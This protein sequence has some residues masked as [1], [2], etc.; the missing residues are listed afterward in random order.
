MLG[1]IIR[2]IILG[3]II[4]VGVKYSVFWAIV[5]VMGWIAME[6]INIEEAEL[7]RIQDIK[8]AKEAKEAKEAQELQ[9]L[10]KG[11]IKNDKLNT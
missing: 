5:S 8:D 9:E 3:S 2:L 11:E 4:F 1:I 10:L 6:L 7:Q